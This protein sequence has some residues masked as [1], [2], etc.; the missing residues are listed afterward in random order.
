MQETAA[1]RGLSSSAGTANHHFVFAAATHLSDKTQE[2]PNLIR[3]LV[4]PLLGKEEKVCMCVC[5]GAIVALC[6]HNSFRHGGSICLCTLFSH[7]DIQKTRQLSS[8]PAFLSY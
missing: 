4:V 1:E 2:R 8:A 6:F 3:G 5:I 7:N